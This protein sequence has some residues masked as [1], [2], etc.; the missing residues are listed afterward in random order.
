[1]QKSGLILSID[2]DNSEK[3]V[4][5]ITSLLGSRRTIEK[6]YIGGSFV[7]DDEAIRNLLRVLDQR[8]EQNKGQLATLKCD[9]Y[10][11][12]GRVIHLLSRQ[13]FEAYI[14]QSNEI[15]MGI[16]ITIS[17]LVQFSDIPEKQDIRFQAYTKE[18]IKYLISSSIEY[19]SDSLIQFSVEATN[20]T[21]AED[22][23]RHIDTFISK[24]YRTDPFYKT[25]KLLSSRSAFMFYIIAPVIAMLCSLAW[26]LRDNSPAAKLFKEAYVKL[27]DTYDLQAIS[28]KANLIIEQRLNNN[29]ELSVFLYTIGTAIIVMVTAVI[30]SVLYRH[31]SQSFFIIN[32]ATRKKCDNAQKINSM[33]KISIYLALAIGIVSSVLA[34]HID[35]YLFN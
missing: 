4:A 27:K 15:S 19:D 18:S 3:I 24:Y 17:F 21:W 12:N 32:E 22:V 2:E 30:T 7:I 23:Y 34:T 35:R 5:F 13:D 11:K 8:I 26:K 1:M 33:I 16:D 6:R 28:N 25:I 9:I 20:V 10:F 31:F 29:T 14:D